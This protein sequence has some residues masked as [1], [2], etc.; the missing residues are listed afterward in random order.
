M[1]CACPSSPQVL[2]S[3]E[4]CEDARARPLIQEQAFTFASEGFVQFKSMQVGGHGRL[5]GVQ[6]CRMGL[7]AGQ[8]G[9]W[10]CFERA[11]AGGP[12]SF[13]TPW[14]PGPSHLDLQ[15]SAS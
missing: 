13:F 10:L 12:A 5:G 9:L 1:V 6:L 3:Q 2:C 8:D 7:P 11:F 15:H 4:V 14:D